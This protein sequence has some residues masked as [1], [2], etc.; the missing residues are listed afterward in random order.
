MDSS[1]HEM[2]KVGFLGTVNEHQSEGRQSQFFQHNTSTKM[3]LIQ[4]SQDYLPCKNECL[5]D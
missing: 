4:R 2:D 5:I 1:F 3:P